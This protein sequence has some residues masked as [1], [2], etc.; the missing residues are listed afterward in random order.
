[1]K[2]ATIIP[3]ALA[4]MLAVTPVAAQDHT[5][6]TL[7]GACQSEVW[8][9][10]FAV[11]IMAAGPW[12]PVAIALS[13]MPREASANQ[14]RDVIM[15]YLQDNPELRHH[16]FADVITMAIYDAWPCEGE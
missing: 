11:G 10:A 13:C 9:N 8:C 6:E 3:G 12:S 15:K 4:G 5:G 1:M 2:S 14:L 7:Y 16:Y